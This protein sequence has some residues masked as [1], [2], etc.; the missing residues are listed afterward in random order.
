MIIFDRSD[1]EFVFDWLQNFFDGGRSS[2]DNLS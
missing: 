2:G 1:S